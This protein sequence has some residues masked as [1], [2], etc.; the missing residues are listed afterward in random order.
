MIIKGYKNSKGQRITRKNAKK[1]VKKQTFPL[2]FAFY[3][4]FESL[5]FSVIREETV[6]AS[7]PTNSVF[8]I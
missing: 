6:F 2:S 1:S 3:I 8:T 5:T 4:Q 7:F